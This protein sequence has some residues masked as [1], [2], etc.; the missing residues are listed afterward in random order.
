MDESINDD[1]DLLNDDS[2]TDRIVQSIKKHDINRLNEFLETSHPSDIAEVMDDLDE[3]EHAIY[4][5]RLCPKNIQSLVLVEL[6]EELQATL[7]DELNIKEISNIVVNLESDDLTQLVSEIPKEKAEQILNSIDQ[8]DSSRIRDQLKFE[9]H[10]AGRI[11]S[12]EFAAVKEEELVKKGI[13]Y[14]KKLAKENKSFYL[15]YVV[16]LNGVVIGYVSIKDLFFANP[17]AK[18]SEIMKADIK[19]LHYT[20]DQEEVARFFQKYNYVSAAVVDDQGKMIG[21]ITVDDIL[22]VVEEEATEDL[23]LMG[24][25]SEEEKVDD[26]LLDSVKSRITWLH[27]NLLTAVMA[28]SV[29]AFF[30]GTIDKVVVLASLMPIVAGLGGNAGTQAITVMVRNIATGE[31]DDKNWKFAIIKELMIGAVNGLILGTVTA[32]VAFVFKHNIYLSLVIGIAMF[33]NQIVAGL[34][35]SSVPIL[36]KFFGIDPAVASSIFVTAFTDT[37]GFF[38]F[39]GL[40]NLFIQYLM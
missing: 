4:L 26:S 13:A 35:G 29:V 25:V 17:R 5:F 38:C 12:N 1:F 15:L 28:S 31:L 24:G 21:R 22:D 10:T 3:E 23:L 40:S 14:L 6:S 9:E 30:E 7:V 8:E 19:T 27:L 2:I 20:T 32:I 11:M 18:I 33:V 37:F 16:N 36:L 39:L 34:V